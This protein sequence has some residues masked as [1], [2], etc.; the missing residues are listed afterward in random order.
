MLLTTKQWN[1]ASIAIKDHC[2]P[3]KIHHN[4]DEGHCSYQPIFFSTP[5]PWASPWTKSMDYHNGELKFQHALN[6]SL[7]IH[8]FDP[9][10]CSFRNAF[11]I[12]KVKECWSS[13]QEPLIFVSL[14][15]SWPIKDISLKKIEML[16]TASIADK[17]SFKQQRPLELRKSCRQFP[18]NSAV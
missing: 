6:Q 2:G 3:W 15:L 8:T 9:S 11:K 7:Q 13:N 5:S 1:L 16:Q 14:E 17:L 4:Q 10:L 12:W 18:R